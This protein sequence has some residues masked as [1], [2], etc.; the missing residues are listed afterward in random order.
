MSFKKIVRFILIIIILIL[1]FTIIRSTYSK[2]VTAIDKNTGVGLNAWNIKVNNERITTDA[3]FTNNLIINFDENPNIA[4]NTIAP[5]R[6]GTVSLT[7]DSTGTQVPYEYKIEIVEDNVN[8][9]SNLPDYKIYAY[10]LNGSEKVVLDDT[11]TSITGIV[12]PA[13]DITTEVKNNVI[14]YVEWYDDPDNIMDNAADVKVT[15]EDNPFGTIPIGV[16]LTQIYE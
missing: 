1:L 9:E 7:L 6:T 15:Q 11:I 10:S 4:P 2:Y 3:N 8:Y 12:Q 14:L 13:A 5:T 16:S